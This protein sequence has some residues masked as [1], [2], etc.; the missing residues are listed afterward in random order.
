MYR[1][2]P[3]L[4]PVPAVVLPGG[5]TPNGPDRQI[6][7]G[8]HGVPS[9]EVR[10]VQRARIL[11]AFVQ[12]VGRRGLDKAHIC[13]VCR[14]AGVSTRGFYEVFESKDQCL[15]EAFEVG[16]RQV[17]EHGAATFRLAEGTWEKRL[18]SA[19]HVML[20]ILS[21]NPDFSRLAIVEYRRAGAEERQRFDEVIAYCHQVFGNGPTVAPPGMS[22]EVYQSALVGSLLGPL[23]GCVTM[24]RPEDLVD[25][26]TLLTYVI[27][28]H[29]VGEKRAKAVVRMPTL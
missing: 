12:E 3:T 14:A 24:G 2:T 11:D 1:H 21:A 6:R 28:L 13:Q 16:A 9:H 10:E 8:R 15:G 22:Q 5:R 26:V 7:R 25:L 20:G 27:A 18:R 17:C 29:V 4:P 19:I 23:S